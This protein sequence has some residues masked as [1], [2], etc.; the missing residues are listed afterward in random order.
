MPTT[1][2]FSPRRGQSYHERSQARKPHPS[3]KTTQQYKGSTL[4]VNCP[5]LDDRRHSVPGFLANRS[6]IQSNT[7][8]TSVSSLNDSTLR[9]LSLKD[10]LTLTPADNSSDTVNKDDWV[11]G[12]REGIIAQ[13]RGQGCDSQSFSNVS[14]EDYRYVIQAIADDDKRYKLSYTPSSQRLV[15]TLPTQLH[16]TF[17]ASL[18]DSIHTALKSIGIDR[19][20][21]KFVIQ[22]NTTLRGRGS[23]G[24]Q[25]D[26]L[27]I[28]DMIAEFVDEESGCLQMWGI[29]VSLSETQEAAMTSLKDY[30]T[31]APNLVALT[32]FDVKETAKHVPPT[33]SS[34][35]AI[36]LRRDEKV[37]P[38]HQW[39]R[40]IDDSNH[41]VDVFNHKWVSPLRITVTTWLRR[42]DST[43]ID[44]TDHS[45][46]YYATAVISPDPDSVAL[47]HMQRVL[48]RTLTAIKNVTIEHIDTLKA[49]VAAV[50]A[51]RAAAEEGNEGNTV[52][53]VE[54]QDTLLAA[55]AWV[56]PAS[57]ADW[58][59]VID[60]IR[61]GARQTGYT[62]Y[63]TWHAGLLKK[64]KASEMSRSKSSTSKRTRRG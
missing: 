29:E 23:E 21:G 1:L 64:R 49:E 10:P 37:V 54:F 33:D 25:Q 32:W 44:L 17:L 14:R 57:L 9:D 46:M 18:P 4:G 20:S 52:Q 7:T 41:A 60:D 3:N 8:A 27:G 24:S 40:Q 5:P 47:T 42:P 51:A 48:N 13:I 43:R 31:D 56:P 36:A 63:S 6:G 50:A 22:K 55:R 16:E 19:Q 15:S 26:S 62:R 28:P 11:I 61:S 35:T 34:Q 45:A 53:P 38:Y 58:E 2:T 59:E 39:A 12:F 30:V